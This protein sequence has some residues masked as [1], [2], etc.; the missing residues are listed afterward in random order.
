MKVM[1]TA[2]KYIYTGY[3]ALGDENR[4]IRYELIDGVIYFMSPGA[5]QAHQ[6]TS[7]ELFLQLAIYLKGKPCEV[8]HPPFDVCLNAKGDEDSS[9]VQPDIIVVC[10]KSKLDGKRCNG[11]P[12]LIIEILSPSN[13]KYDLFI[14]FRAYLKAGV[15]EYWVVDPD[16][17]TVQTYILKGGKYMA[18]AYSE[19]SAVPVHVLP[20]LEIDM[21]KVFQF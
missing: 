4:D 10:D 13:K 3:A 5:S 6:T 18:D 14:K 20:G 9:T 12:D 11:A 15:R 7:R 1:E 8:F 21:Q 17:K 16:E 2:E 19:E